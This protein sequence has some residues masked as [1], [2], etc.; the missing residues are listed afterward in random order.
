[1]SKLNYSRTSINTF[2]RK[3]KGIAVI[4]STIGF[5]LIVLLTINFN[6]SATP[7]SVYYIEGAR[8]LLGGLGFQFQDSEGLYSVKSHWPPLYSILIAIISKLFTQDPLVVVKY[9]TACLFSI[10]IY[11][12][13]NIL[14]KLGAQK[15]IAQ[16][17]FNLFLI[18]STASMVNF[19]IWSEPL[20]ICLMLLIIS[21]SIKWNNERDVKR[22]ILLGSLLGLLF[23][24][25]YAA[26]GIILGILGF[27][28]LNTKDWQKKVIGITMCLF[29]ILITVMPWIIFLKLNASNSPREFVVHFIGK[30]H[31]NQMF[32]T[33]AH[34][35]F[36]YD[37]S[38]GEIMLILAFICFVVFW[39]KLVPTPGL[40]VISFV[41]L[42]YIIFL[43]LSISF[44]DFHTPLNNRILAPI[45]PL[46]LLLIFI[47]LQTWIEKKSGVLKS[48]MYILLIVL[49]GF[50]IKTYS[51]VFIDRVNHG[52]MYTGDLWTNSETM[53]SI[54][55]NYM[56][57][58]IYTNSPD[59]IKLNTGRVLGVKLVPV[60][61]SPG[62]QRLNENYDKEVNVL[63]SDLQNK[64][65]VVVFFK[66]IKREYLMNATEISKL[67][68]QV[69]SKE[70]HDGVV[71]H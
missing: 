48:T 3:E 46:L 61:Y 43:F 67:L 22:I 40:K 30:T 15:R 7:D 32:E 19:Y 39:R 12:T 31:L 45:F 9:V 21:L 59:V 53:V 35:V 24:T 70:H 33:L 13:N 69:N 11:I 14:F 26:A 29:G 52:F 66:R 5:L 28:Y 38:A 16:I 68:K 62:Q 44:F 55:R 20:F 41:I 2:E 6:L 10:S 42:S 23:L 25:R 54:K 17:I 56:N 8:N 64:K 57:K 60:K 49:C 51:G 36:P 18:F 4:F 65:A 27:I 50:H 63:I 37:K 34:W 1:M 71:F 58:T 47:S